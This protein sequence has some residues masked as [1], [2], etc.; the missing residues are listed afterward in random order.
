MSEAF[1][2]VF[3]R[4][5]AGKKRDVVRKETKVVRGYP[6]VGGAVDMLRDAPGFLLRVAREHPG[7]ITGIRLGP[8]T[9]YLVTHPDHVQTVLQDEWRSFGKSGGMWK[10]AA[11]VFGKGIAVSEGAVWLRQ[12]RMMQPLFNAQ[13]L[14]ALTDLMIDVIDREVTQLAAKGSATVDMERE[15]GAMTQRVMLAT[16]LGQDVDRGEIDRLGDQIAIALTELNLR[17]FLY[18]LPDRFPLPGER[19]YRRAIAA[20]DEAM[21]RF[22]RARR[23][24]P[25]SG[26]DDLLSLLLAARDEETGEGM[27]DRQ[28]RD[29][30]VTMYVAG[31]ETTAMAMTWLW[32]ALDQ[33]PEVDRRVR[34]EI[35]AVV[36][37]RR[38]TFDDLAR[39]RYT[40]QVIQEVLRLYP[41]VWMY[42]RFAD[43]DVTIDGHRIPAGSTLLLCPYATQRDPAF[44]PDPEVFDPE[45][46][47]PERSLGRPRYAYYPFS[48]GP[49]QC[50]GNHFTMME[51][52][53]I[54]AMMAQ[55][56]RPKLVP[57]HPV[58]P[59]SSPSLKPRYGM[60]MTLDRGAAEEPAR[61]AVVKETKVVRGYPLVGGALDMLRDAP[62]LLTRVAR[63]APGEIVGVRLGPVTAYVVTHPDHVQQVLQDQWRTFGKGGNMWKA[64][65][66]LMGNGIVMS[67]G[68]HWLRQRR[69]MQPLF[70]AGHL[71][72]LTDVMVDV[73]DREVSRL[74]AKGSATVDMSHEMFVLAQRLILETMLGKGLDPV[75]M[76]RLALDLDVA[77]KGLSTR[78]YLHFLPEGFPLPGERRYRAALAAIDERVLRMVRARRAQGAIGHDLLS[79]LLQARDEDTGEGMDDRQLRDE[80]VCLFVA[81]QDTTA[82]LMAWLWYVLDQNPEVERRLRAEVADVLGDRKPVFDDLARLS[83]TKRVLQETLRLYPPGWLFFRSADQETIIDGHRI[84]AGATLLLCPFASHRDPASWP[85]P[86]VF[87]PER[88]T[89]ERSAGRPRYAYYPFAGGP[90]QCIGNHM[91]MMEA[92]LIT[93]MMVQRLRP[94]LVPGHRVEPVSR[95]SLQPRDGVKVILGP[96]PGAEGEAPLRG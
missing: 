75:E 32:Y 49:H 54:T 7:E 12:R 85:E 74:A 88:F 79:L 60:K 3:A 51:A 95:T 9:A 65:K 35:A 66:P 89:P 6:L 94:R 56:M 86:E 25:K 23:E 58:V 82:T 18:F 52:Q 77:F 17:F 84:P 80:F 71:A 28:L 55:R 57:G 70:G 40:K 72:G 21:L 96:A 93:A 63:E 24:S 64:A 91:A 83:Y 30:L 20:I 26:R 31:H 41:T 78:L 5:E 44:W 43:K 45:R 10:A 16:M 73:V 59:T 68:A 14:A 22:V 42:P 33:H 50:I 11:P 19:R 36:G 4:A 81:G 27:T 34:D 92:Q 46:F 37:D 39:L 47:T 1:T 90:H 87:D 48:G 29:E 2:E 67:E 13:S 69:M 38:P 61:A 15:M 53:L 8:V 62:G 76:D